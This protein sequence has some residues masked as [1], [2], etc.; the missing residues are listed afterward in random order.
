M[1]G[2][3]VKLIGGSNE[4]ALKKLRPEVEEVNSLEPEI[5][6]L[7]EEE[8]RSKTDELR[9]R[10]ADGEE[11]DDLLPEA[12]A[13]VREA[14]K[15][16]LA[17]RHFDVQ[18]MGGV[19][20]HQG[21][22]AE[23]KTGEGKTLVST[24]PAYLNALTGRGV[25]I[26]TVNDY[27]ARRDAQWMGGI[28]HLLGVSV[29]V[30]QHQT[31]YLYDPTVESKE[32]GLEKLRP[33]SRREA[34]HADITYGTNN[35]LGFDY[36]RDNM[37]VDLSQRVQRQLAYAIVDEVDNI[38]IDEARTP[39]II[40]GPAEQSPKEYYRFARLVP[41]LL[42]GEDYAIDEKHRTASL[43]VEGIDKLERMLNVDNLYDPSNFNLVH[44]VENALKSHTIFQRDRQ[45]VVKD[46][47]VVIVDEFTGRMMHGRRYSD[48]LHQAIEAKEGLQVQRETITYATITLQNYFRLY[49]KLAGMTGTAATEAEEFWKIYKL[50]VVEIPTNM[51]MIRQDL[52]DLIYKNQKG[53]LNAVVEEIEELHRRGQPVLV[54][55][56]DIDKSEALSE[57]LKLRG[58][59]HEVLNAKHHEREAMIV[60]QAGHSGAVTVA[61]SM[62]GRGTDIVLGGNPA[63]LDMTSEEWERD[64]NRV[65]ELGGLHILGTERH[66]ARRIDNQ[67]RGRTGRQGDPGSS[68]FYVA[69]D[70]ELMRR[71]GGDR[72][73][74]VMDW[75]GIDDETPIENRMISKSIEGA[76]V[77]VEA[78]HFDMR[79]HLVEYDDVVNRHR[80]IIYGERNKTLGGADLKANILSMV[81]S[82]IRDILGA[83]LT[84]N[85]PVNWD[86]ASLL[87]ELSTLLPPP[88]DLS[89]PD[90]LAQMSP[91][92]IEGRLL[93]HA[94][95]M[96]DALEEQLTPETMRAI[97]SRLMLRSI[98]ANWVQHLTAI[99]N[100][101]QG[102]GLHAYGQRD[103][104]VMYKKEGH[105]MFQS[106][107]ARIQRDVAYTI[108]HLGALGDGR[109]TVGGG[110]GRKSQPASGDASVMTRV[111][112]GRRREPVAAGGRKIGR[113]EPC[114]CDSGKKYKRCH[115]AA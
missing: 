5:E 27:L 58:I 97:E 19:V 47:E 62:A 71:F 109:T 39:L 80:D 45:Y 111:V 4:K 57:K 73:R 77:K 40:S 42:P 12:F 23:M 61:T 37:V 95:G 100:L 52:G 35:E 8:L 63:G 90:I 91:E 18:L 33:V 50:D 86:T 9:G 56:T 64:H 66:D 43:T 15:R 85:A 30:L 49:E 11:L 92:E 41:N 81:E 115:G 113:N 55:T 3:L 114:P 89:D 82:E 51:P 44:F 104:L 105:E 26:V 102:I 14:A 88:P 108:Y 53:K 31:A 6:R 38:L 99:E 70:D 78:H 32:R 7:S 68:R 98:D 16:T 72:I 29:G 21:R 110:R 28:Y 60:A 25:H 106:L 87:R 103:P 17:Q 67:L 24:L 59:P 10:L 93:E 83:Y 79:K 76:Q 22:I 48:G 84:D 101:R 36:L 96:Y 13:A 74:A 2:G 34:Y 75:A 65:L 94:Q 107:Q 1:L 20:L 112:G 69:L 46:G 54:G